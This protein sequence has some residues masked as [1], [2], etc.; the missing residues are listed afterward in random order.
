MSTW[1]IEVDA[2]SGITGTDNGSQ[3]L[4]VPGDFDGATINSVLVVGS[5]TVTSD[6]TTDDTVDIRWNVQSSAPAAIYGGTGSSTVALCDA[7]I[8]DSVSSDV[9]VEGSAPSPAPT[10]AVTAD[11]DNFH[12]TCVY[13]SSGMPDGETVSW[14][15]FTVQVTYTPTA[16][17]WG[18]YHVVKQVR[19]G[20]KTLLTM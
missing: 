11:W 3:A 17:P 13:N 10:I 9:I 7:T 8:G 12:Y 15:T 20:W 14:A 2:Q 4:T 19:R 6:S 18:F 16:A 1:D 5:P